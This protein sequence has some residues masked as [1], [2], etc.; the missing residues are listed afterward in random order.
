MDAPLRTRALDLCARLKDT[1]NRVMFELTLLETEVREGKA[2]AEAV[3]RS[4]SGLDAAMLSVMA[5]ATDVVDQLENAAERDEAQERAFVLVIETVG[6]LMQ[7][8]ERAKAATDALLSGA[9]R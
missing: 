7:A 4:L 9:G 2:D 8:L 6:V 3:L 1:S 5:D